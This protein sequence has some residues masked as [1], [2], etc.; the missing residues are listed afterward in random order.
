M[1]LEPREEEERY[2]VSTLLKRIYIVK[3]F[4]RTRRILAPPLE[5][6]DGGRGMCDPPPV[7]VA[8]AGR[9]LGPGR[10]WGGGR[11][12]FPWLQPAQGAVAVAAGK[13]LRP[14]EAMKVKKG[15]GGTG[16]GA[17]PVPG[18][19]NRSVEPTRE[20]G[21]EAESGSESEPE[22]GPGPRLGPLQGKQPIGPE[23]VLGLQRITGGEH[24]RGSAIRGLEGERGR[25]PT[26]LRVRPP[27][28]PHAMPLL[29]VPLLSLPPSLKSLCFSL[30]LLMR[31]SSPCS[32]FFSPHSFFKGPTPFPMV[33]VGQQL[34]L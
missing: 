4:T 14:R 24:R 5:M 33:E 18:T 10:G 31:P 6:P 29:C 25:G 21:A 1:R 13:D 27:P 30:G 17:E 20:P 23:D 9:H 12:P 2:S 22:P 11:S 32:G 3:K 28:L 15:G 16:P 19:S 26:R 34:H 7:G 8:K